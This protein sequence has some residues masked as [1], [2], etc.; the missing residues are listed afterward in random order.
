[1][2]T[3]T[4][5]ASGVKWTHVTETGSWYRDWHHSITPTNNMAPS[6]FMKETYNSWNTISNTSKKDD[7]QIFILSRYFR[8]LLCPREQ[9]VVAKYCDK[10]VYVCVRVSVCLQGY[11]RNSMRNVYQI[12]CACC[13]W[14]W[15]G[16]P[17]ALLQYT[18]YFRYCGWYHVFSIMGHIAVWILLQRTD[19]T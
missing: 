6:R 10:Y 18:M 4:C 11:L 16:P 5:F 14:P 8:D 19:F 7:W 3:I 9:G 1:M 15:F 13:L 12:F 17:W 2:P